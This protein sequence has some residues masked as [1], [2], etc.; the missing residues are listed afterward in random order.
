MFIYA[1]YIFFFEIFEKCCLEIKTKNQAI[2]PIDQSKLY[3]QTFPNA[4]I[5]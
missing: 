4:A 3:S 2:N 1:L 5:F